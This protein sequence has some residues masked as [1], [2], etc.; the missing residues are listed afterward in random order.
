MAST[1]KD[2]SVWQ[3]IALSDFN[4]PTETVSREA[5]TNL[6]SYL[7]AL[8]RKVDS[9]AQ[10]IS[11]TQ[12]ELQ[13]LPDRLFERAVRTPEWGEMGVRGLEDALDLWLEA[14]TDKAGI[15]V[16]VHGPF[17][18]V[19]QSVELLAHRRDWHV[20]PIPSTEKLFGGG[21]AWQQDILPPDG[22]RWVI[23][24]LERSYLRH[25][26]GLNQVRRLVERIWQ[27]GS[28]GLITCESWAWAYL[29]EAIQISSFFPTPITLSPFG[30]PRL[31]LWLERM[32]QRTFGH[33]FVFR[34]AASGKEIFLPTAVAIECLQKDEDSKEAS[35]EN[36]QRSSYLRSLA[37]ASRGNP[38]IAWAIWRASL[39]LAA[40]EDLDAVRAGIDQAHAETEAQESGDQE[41]DEDSE[42]V[43]KEKARAAARLDKGLT[44]WIRQWDDLE[45]PRLPANAHTVEAF[46]LH[47]LLIHGGLPHRLLSDL[48]PLQPGALLS[49]MRR[50]QAVGIVHESIESL[51]RVTP[52]AYPAVRSFLSREGYL[53]DPL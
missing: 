3:F 25:Y 20:V 32:A 39:Y 37:V 31:S 5:V 26:S 36:N 51:W 19:A 53:L 49:G 8:G 22:G 38:G 2:V 35:L 43:V 9:Q 48:L 24:R 12:E 13:T 4:R 6:R 1:N 41:T 11:K 18:G 17:D 23:P 10:P 50:L 15:Q 30:V 40:D 29:N 14:E 46:I 21:V 44:V 34:S 42:P 28:A 45:L 16:I 7:R 33:R 47:A 52:A 27:S